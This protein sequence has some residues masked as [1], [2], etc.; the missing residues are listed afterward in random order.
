[1]DRHHEESEIG[2][3][4]DNKS[5]FITGATGFMGKVLVEKLLRSCPGIKN[6]YLLLRSKKGLNAGQRLDEL[7]N[8]KIF[9]SLN[10]KSSSARNKV[11]PIAGDI[12]EPGLG[13]S[14]HDMQKLINEVHV[15]F[16]SAA[17]VKFDEPLR[18]SIQYNVLGTRRV[19]QLCH[20]MT[21][22]K[23]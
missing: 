22:L 21:N 2:R 16:H 1:M 8:A 9:D 15:V 3:F 12:A 14:E 10:R 13:I 7:F 6:I 23:V 19:I 5:V 11:L 4:F 17:T 18:A 20:K